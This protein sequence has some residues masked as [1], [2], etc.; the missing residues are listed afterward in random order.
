M[1]GSIDIYNIDSSKTLIYIS[2]CFFPMRLNLF[3]QCFINSFGIAVKLLIRTP[4]SHAKTTSLSSISSALDL[5]CCLRACWEAVMVEAA[6][7]PS[8]QWETHMEF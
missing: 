5:A 8:H 6:G 1:F 2:V 4:T 3:Y 7:L